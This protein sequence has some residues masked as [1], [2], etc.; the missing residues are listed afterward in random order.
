M[1]LEKFRR[2]FVLLL[3]LT[4]AAG[5]VTHS[6]HADYLGVKTAAMASNAMTTDMPMPGKCDGCAGNENT[7]M[8]MACAAFCSSVAMM[9]VMTVAVT[10]V[11]VGTLLP[12]AGIV[13]TG[14]ISPP[15]PYP[16]RPIVLS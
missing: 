5:L 8:P 14:H 16:P 4:L 3:A 11:P 9:P 15:D 12:P 10:A 1:V 2:L 7:L 6:A 13:A